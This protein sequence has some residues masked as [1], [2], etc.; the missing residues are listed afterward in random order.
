MIK[1]HIDK[2]KHDKEKDELNEEGLVN[3][4]RPLVEEA[5]KILR[6]T[7]GA[8]KA[9]DPDG[10]IANHAS[11]KAKDHEATKEEQH[12]ADSLAKLTGEVTQAIEEARDFIKDMPY[13]SLSRAL[14]SV[15]HCS[16][17]K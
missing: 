5:T 14:L 16:Y 12:L 11:R 4:V 10:T 15:F 7:H 1:K 8:I 3:A 6:E 2:A 13:V 9:L 17:D